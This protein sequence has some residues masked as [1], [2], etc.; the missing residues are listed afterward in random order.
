MATACNA[1]PSSAGRI[2]LLLHVPVQRLADL[3]PVALLADL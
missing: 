1:R 2:S 3:S